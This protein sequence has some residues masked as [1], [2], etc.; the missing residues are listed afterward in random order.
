MTSAYPSSDK[1]KISRSHG[2]KDLN[3]T[4]NNLNEGASDSTSNSYLKDIAPKKNTFERRAW[5]TS[6]VP[7]RTDRLGRL[8][9]L[10]SNKNNSEEPGGHLH[11]NKWAQIIIRARQ[12]Q[13]LQD[14]EDSTQEADVAGNITTGGASSESTS[15]DS[16]NT[17]SSTKFSDILFTK[18]SE[19]HNERGKSSGDGTKYQTRT[20]DAKLTKLLPK[21]GKSMASKEKSQGKT[22]DEEE[23]RR[24]C[25]RELEK[26]LTECG[27]GMHAQLQ[28]REKKPKKP[29]HP[30]ERKHM[31]TDYV[32]CRMCRTASQ[33]GLSTSK[34]ENEHTASSTSTRTETADASDSGKPEKKDSST[35]SKKAQKDSDAQSNSSKTKSCSSGVS[36]PASEDSEPSHRKSD[37]CSTTSYLELKANE[38]DFKKSP[39]KSKSLLDTFREVA[40]KSV[41]RKSLL[42]LTTKDLNAPSSSHNTTTDDLSGYC[43]ESAQDSE[44]QCVGAN[45]NLAH[46]SSGEIKVLNQSSIDRG[47]VLR[48]VVFYQNRFIV[49]DQTKPSNEKSKSPLKKS[50][51]RE[52]SNDNVITEPHDKNFCSLNVP[53]KDLTSKEKTDVRK[54]ESSFSCDTDSGKDLNVDKL[55]QLG[56]ITERI[57][58]KDPSKICNSQ[59]TTAVSSNVN[60]ESFF[61]DCMKKSESDIELDIYYN[62]VQNIKLEPTYLQL[63]QKRETDRSSC[64]FSTEHGACSNTVSQ[65]DAKRNRDL[66]QSRDDKKDEVDLEHVEEDLG[67]DFELDTSR[68][69]GSIQDYQSDYESSSEHIIPDDEEPGRVGLRRGQRKSMVDDDDYERDH[70]LAQKESLYERKIRATRHASFSGERQH[71]ILRHDKNVENTG[72]DRIL[73]YKGDIQRGG[74]EVSMERQTQG[75][76]PSSKV[77]RAGHSKRHTECRENQNADNYHDKYPSEEEMNSHYSHEEMLDDMDDHRGNKR[78]GYEPEDCAYDSEDYRETSNTYCTDQHNEAQILDDEKYYCNVD[79]DTNDIYRYNHKHQYKPQFPERQKEKGHPHTDK[80]KSGKRNKHERYRDTGFENPPKKDLKNQIADFENST[81]RSNR[82]VQFREDRRK[83]SKTIFQKRSSDT[84]YSNVDKRSFRDEKVFYETSR[85]SSLDVGLYWKEMES[86]SGERSRLCREVRRFTHSSSLDSNSTSLLPPNPHKNTRSNSTGRRERKYLATRTSDNA[87][88]MTKRDA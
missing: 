19:Q 11:N 12:R 75:E 17:I 47:N 39:R 27:F 2:S 70:A 35:S 77:A 48:S 40:L 25:R 23:Y 84:D 81:P 58:I 50:N 57:E 69:L 21:S 42:N 67:G 33:T 22:E 18:K 8:P 43:F 88:N 63:S 76:S 16:H 34:K 56:G 73:R 80:D 10:D 14:C 45:K 74:H 68:L 66:I 46:K 28:V 71:D 78:S 3:A 54:N 87:Q 9:A 61:T 82:N 26:R 36:R 59:I 85:Q 38:S 1:N 5:V 7:G 51:T 29:K 52:K 65:V 15:A 41:R 20:S 4:S 62:R 31:D 83:V 86:F 24:Q 53:D 72:T 60:M 64:N 6:L 13:N 55:G 37:D 79:M 32:T 30:N 49:M 44:D